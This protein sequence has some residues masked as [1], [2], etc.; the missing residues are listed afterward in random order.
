MTIQY[1]YWPKD[2]NDPFLEQL[3]L[4][5][6][7]DRNHFDPLF[8]LKDP[9]SC[10]SSLCEINFSLNRLSFAEVRGG[11]LFDPVQNLEETV[12]WRISMRFHFWSTLIS[13]RNYWSRG[14]EKTLLNQLE[15]FEGWSKVKPHTFASHDCLLQILNCIKKYTPGYWTASKS[16]DQKLFSDHSWTVVTSIWFYASCIKTISMRTTKCSILSINISRRLT[17]C[18]CALFICCRIFYLIID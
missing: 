1:N 2:K 14:F 5:L 4:L 11:K 12:T 16:M 6:L 9:F 3:V 8:Y 17:Q 15:E 7:H 18:H 10:V 13:L